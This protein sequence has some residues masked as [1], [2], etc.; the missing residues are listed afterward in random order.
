MTEAFELG[1]LV[2]LRT[3]SRGGQVAI[4][5]QPVTAS[6]AGHVLTLDSAGLVGLAVVWP[7]I[8]A[9]TEDSRGFAQLAYQ[10][11]RLGSHVIESRLIT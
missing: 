2:V 11:I 8:E 3:A 7:D 4:V 6:R 9:A 10:L 5:S 1:S